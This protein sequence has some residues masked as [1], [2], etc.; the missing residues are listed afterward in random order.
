MSVGA[1]EKKRAP[2]AYNL[3]VKEHMKTYL[4]DNPGKTNKDAMKH[5]CITVMG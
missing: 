5:V 2:S 3:F 1:K 4:A